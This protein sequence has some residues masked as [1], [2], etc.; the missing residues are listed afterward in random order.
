MSNYYNLKIKITL[1]SSVIT[2]FH[3]DTIFGHICWGYRYQFG[4][5]EFLDNFIPAFNTET[6][7]IIL[8]NAFPESYLPMPI[9]P[10]DK[11]NLT[12]YKF[13]HLKYIDRDRFKELNSNGITKRNVFEVYK[14]NNLEYLP[15][16][17]EFLHTSIDRISGSALEKHLYQQEETFYAENT[18]FDLYCKIYY[19]MTPEKFNKCL[20]YI[21]ISGFGKDKSSGKGNVELKITDESVDFSLNNP[22]AFMNL[23]NYVPKKDDP[24]NGN[25]DIFTKFG[26]L[27]GDFANSPHDGSGIIKPFKKPVLMIKPGSTFYTDNCKEFYGRVVD[28]IRT[29]NGYIKQYG[30]SY[31]IPIKIGE[32]D[33]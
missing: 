32:N 6:P 31:P 29:D 26:K 30:I 20:E 2:P 28:N 8:S 27:G 7:S 22:N 3:S 17:E 25:Y 15:V 14:D 21:N 18:V 4:E 24:V 11:Q 16:T 19:P 12:D 13:K 23:S 9:L 5:R 33:E 1:K 10:H